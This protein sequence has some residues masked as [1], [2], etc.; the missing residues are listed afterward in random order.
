MGCLNSKQ[1]NVDDPKSTTQS[2]TAQK[3]ADTSSNSKG[4]KG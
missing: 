2:Q 4:P 1:K 3:P